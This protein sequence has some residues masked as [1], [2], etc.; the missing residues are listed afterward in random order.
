M[1]VVAFKMT[2][3]VPVRVHDSWANVVGEQNAPRNVFI[4]DAAGKN[5]IRQ[6]TA[7]GLDPR[8]QIVQFSRGEFAIINE[9]LRMKRREL[10]NAEAV[11]FLWIGVDEIAEDAPPVSQTPK[12]V[13]EYFL[14]EGPRI[15][16]RKKTSEVANNYV[17]TVLLALSLFPSARIYSSDPMPR[18]ST[19][20]AIARANLVAK[21]MKRQDDRHHHLLLNRHFHGKRCRGN[22]DRGGK[23]PIHD[24][25]FLD[26]VLP[27]IDSWAKVFSRVYAAMNK[28]NGSNAVLEALSFV[29]IAF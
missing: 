20:F 14:P 16:P 3:I 19:G 6:L 10:S 1:Q 22:F 24:K 18:R 11:I 23:Y 9:F 21:Q 12:A 26:G 2:G 25:F 13:E 17:E 27:S 8:D 29:K 28:L 4:V 15:I 7:V 5:A